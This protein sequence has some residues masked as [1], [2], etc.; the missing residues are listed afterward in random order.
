MLEITFYKRVFF[1]ILI[2]KYS[3][4]CIK[5]KLRAIFSMQALTLDDEVL[6]TVK[7]HATAVFGI[8]NSYGRRAEKQ[9]RV[10]GTLLGFVK[11]GCVEVT[12]CFGVPHHE[13]SQE[14]YVAI[15]KDYHKSMYNFHRV[16]NR[17]EQIVGWYT[18]TTAEGASIID[19]S[20]PI[21]DFYSME[22][23]NPIHLVLDTTLAGDNMGL[24][25]FIGEPIVVG[26]VNFATMFQEINVEISLSNAETSCLY[27]M[28]HGQSSPWESSQLVSDISNEA[29][30][31]KASLSRLVALIDQVL[32]YVNGVVDGSTP[33]SAEVGVALADLLGTL[34]S[35]NPQDF[36]ALFQGKVQ[37]LLM[38]SYLSTLMKTQLS[39]AERLNSII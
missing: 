5:R 21:H 7:V 12:D 32:S 34:Q 26:D 17:K 24:K 8:L 28:I 22:C 2:A 20:S 25:A 27:H 6:P 3:L 29:A 33:P 38:V 14:I 35:M 36:N 31:I 30:S 1:N 37:D 16:V 18:T 23:A 9:S 10:I 15:D 11:D 4:L 39:L 13:K 19:N